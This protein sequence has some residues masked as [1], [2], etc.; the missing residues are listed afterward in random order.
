MLKKWWFWSVCLFTLIEGVIF[1]QIQFSAMSR[2]EIVGLIV[3]PFSISLIPLVIHNWREK[4]IDRE[5]YNGRRLLNVSH[6]LGATIFLASA[7]LWYLPKDS[8]YMGYLFSY[9]F[10]GCMTFSV[11]Y[12]VLRNNK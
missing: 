1:S 11:I 10:L 4:G 2:G 12:S 9:M 3:I 8:I 6:V 5:S 7:A